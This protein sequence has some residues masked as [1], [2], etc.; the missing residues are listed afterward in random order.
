MNHNISNVGQP[1]FFPPGK[2]YRKKYWEKINM[3]RSIETSF[4]YG[5]KS[6][7][8]K[9]WKKINIDKTN[10]DK[11]FPPGKIYWKKYWEKDKY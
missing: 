4:F 5:T 6:I 2:I 11:L 7:E 9:Y 1:H 3:T 10:W 8:K